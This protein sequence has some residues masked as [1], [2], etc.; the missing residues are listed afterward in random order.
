V[1]TGTLQTL[2][3]LVCVVE[4]VAA[5][6]LCLN[7]MVETIQKWRDWSFM[8]LIFPVTL[9]V[10]VTFYTIILYFG[11]TLLDALVANYEH[12]VSMIVILLEIY[13]VPR[14]LPK[15]KREVGLRIP[16]S[17]VFRTTYF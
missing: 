12:G 4:H 8:V 10:G 17:A 11:K 3:F 2:Y 15:D 1:I 9:F 13:F 7:H 5:H 16:C 14:P 6:Y